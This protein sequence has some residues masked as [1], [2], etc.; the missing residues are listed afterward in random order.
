VL[1]HDLG[2]ERAVRQHSAVTVA[3]GLQRLHHEPGAVAVALVLGEDPGVRDGVLTVVLAVVEVADQ[4]V[5]DAD[6]EA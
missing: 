3:D 4:L 2:D 6:L 5:V 1:A